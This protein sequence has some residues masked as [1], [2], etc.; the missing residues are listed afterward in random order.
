MVHDVIGWRRDYTNNKVPV[1][2]TPLKVGEKFQG[3]SKHKFTIFLDK[4]YSIT[5]IRRLNLYD[6]AYARQGEHAN[7]L[8]DNGFPVLFVYPPCGQ[9]EDTSRKWY[10]RN[11]RVITGLKLKYPGLFVTE[12]ERKSK[13]KTR[14]KR[15]SHFSTKRNRRTK[16]RN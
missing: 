1:I 6:I 8:L 14:E 7:F 11:S 9:K 13:R 2:N 16:R 4:L 12:N 15:R 3:N 10:N 5:G